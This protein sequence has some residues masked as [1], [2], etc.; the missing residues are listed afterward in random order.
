MIKVE[1]LPTM[2]ACF[3][4]YIIILPLHQ[5]NFLSSVCWRPR[6]CL[7]LWLWRSLIQTVVLFGLVVV[8]KFNSDRCTMWSGGCGEVWP[9]REVCFHAPGGHKHRHLDPYRG[10]GLCQRLD[11]GHVLQW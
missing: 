6:Y 3:Y 7:V 5:T 11:Q 2:T 9:D 8:E 1:L 10:V 4:N